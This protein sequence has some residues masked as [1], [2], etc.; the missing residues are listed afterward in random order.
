MSRRSSGSTPTDEQP[1]TLS[2]RRS[3]T[4]AD[5]PDHQG[6]AHAQRKIEEAQ[7][8]SALEEARRKQE[9]INKNNAV[10][11]AKKKQE[12]AFKKLPGF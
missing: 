4:S 1:V 10:E 2:G 5:A 7:K 11:E 8:N 6:G 12:E 3:C 9:E